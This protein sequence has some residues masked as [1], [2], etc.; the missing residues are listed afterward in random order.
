VIAVV[1]TF[2]AS[3]AVAVLLA[4]IAREPRHRRPALARH[5]AEA[6]LDDRSWRADILRRQHDARLMA[7][8]R[9]ELASAAYAASRTSTPVWSVPRGG[10]LIGRPPLARAA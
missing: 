6:L 8:V 5:L 3:G 1:F 2:V 7:T 4:D 9:A 10:V